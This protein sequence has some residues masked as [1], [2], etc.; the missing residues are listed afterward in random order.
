[1]YKFRRIIT[2]VLLLVFTFYLVLPSPAQAQIRGSWYAPTYNEFVGKVFNPN[3][4]QNE[5]FGE[6]YTLAQVYWILYSIPTFFIGNILGC[7][8]QHPTDPVT[9]STCA[10]GLTSYSSP[11]LD[12]AALIGTIG[13]T[14]PASGVEWV[15]DTA[16]NINIIPQAYAQQGFGFRTLSPTLGLWAQSRNFAYAFLILVI[17]IL[18]FMIMFRVKTSPQTVITVQSAIPQVALAIILITFSYAIAGFLVDLSFLAIGIIAAMVSTSGISTLTVTEAFALINNPFQG[19]MSLGV[20]VITLLSFMIVGSGI[21]AGFL[22]GGLIGV[23][24][25]ILLVLL[26][27]ITFFIAFL[28]VLFLL[29][30][31]YAVIFLLVI[32]APFYLLFGTVMPGLGFMSWIRQMIANLSVF[33][34]AGVLI[35][36]AHVFTWAFESGIGGSVGQGALAPIVNPYEIQVGF[37]ATGGVGVLPVTSGLEPSL[38][39]VL[40][41]LITLL[42]VPNLATVVKNSMQRPSNFGLGIGQALGPAGMLSKELARSYVGEKIGQAEIAEKYAG[43]FGAA[44]S[45]Y[46]KRTNRFWRAAQQGLSKLR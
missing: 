13:Q 31:T 3:A 30:K 42:S 33:V 21:V 40:I 46:G 27:L 12:I 28:R 7:A 43:T 32:A 17:V 29:L 8:I 22:G 26:I 44:S 14:R 24:V 2:T 35:L 1:M 25:S 10:S 20:F 16:A 9:F 36:F 41:G 34:M 45:I 5:V 38:L 4:G 18:A 23:A 11:L 39:G 19:I 15:A 6:R 37:A